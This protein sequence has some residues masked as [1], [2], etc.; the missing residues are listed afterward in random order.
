MAALRESSAAKEAAL[1]AASALAAASHMESARLAAALRRAEEAAETANRL[2]DASVAERERATDAALVEAV[3]SPPRL[4]S[5]HIALRTP[6]NPSNLFP[7]SSSTKS[8]SRTS[9]TRRAW[10]PKQPRTGP[11]KWRL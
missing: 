7:R 5:R 6:Q 11:A 8:P 10:R 1:G 3:R 4:P 2:V 9:A